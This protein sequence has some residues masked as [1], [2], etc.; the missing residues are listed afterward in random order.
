[1]ILC[2]GIRNTQAIFQDALYDGSGVAYNF[3]SFERGLRQLFETF[4]DRSHILLEGV[5]LAPTLGFFKPSAY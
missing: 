4:P 2:F 1:M 5:P 3:V